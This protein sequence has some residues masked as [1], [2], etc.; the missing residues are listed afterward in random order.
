VLAGSIPAGSADAYSDI[1]LRIIAMPDAQA[2]LLAGRLEW[3]AHWGD[4]L[5]N[6]WLDGTHHCISHFRPF[7]KVDVFY[8]TP[9]IFKPSPWFKLPAKV[10]LD[11]IWLVQA[12]LDKSQSLTFAPPA[13]ASPAGS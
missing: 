4:L 7:L 9:D 11:R 5:F 3:P 1:D 13:S 2:R 12:V 6:E 8:W 10:F